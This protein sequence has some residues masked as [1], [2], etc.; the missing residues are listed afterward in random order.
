MEKG[1]KENLLS[2]LDLKNEMHLHM[3][4]CISSGKQ[5]NINKKY[6]NNRL[7]FKKMLKV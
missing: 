7:F 2:L 5:K 3:Q 1:K 6:M 4:K